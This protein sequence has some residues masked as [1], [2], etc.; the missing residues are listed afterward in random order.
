M[1]NSID[2]YKGV[3]LHVLPV[4]IIVLC[5]DEKDDEHWESVEFQDRGA[6][7]IFDDFNDENQ[8]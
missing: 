2:F 3:F 6:F 1:P 8:I 7:D 4:R 5:L